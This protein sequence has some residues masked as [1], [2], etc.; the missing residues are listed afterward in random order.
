MSGSILNG[1]VRKCAQCGKEFRI[2]G[3]VSMWMYKKN[4]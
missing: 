4:I 3:L 1:Q 2:Y